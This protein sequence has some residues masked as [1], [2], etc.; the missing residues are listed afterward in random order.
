VLSKLLPGALSEMLKSEKVGKIMI[1]GSGV[2]PSR[3]N[4]QQICDPAE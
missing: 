3:V 2:I 4:G 1:D